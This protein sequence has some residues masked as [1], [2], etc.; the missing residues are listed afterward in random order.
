M[1]EASN[2]RRNSSRPV[3]GINFWGCCAFAIYDAAVAFAVATLLVPIELTKM[4]RGRSRRQ[5]LRERLGRRG[6]RPV[7]PH[8]HFL[9]H[10]VSVGEVHAAGALVSALIEEDARITVTLT[11]GNIEGRRA[12]G[13]LQQRIPEITSVSFL[14]WDHRVALRGWLRRIRPDATIIVETE[15]WPNLIRTAS[16]LSI[17]VLIVNGRVYPRDVPKYRLARGFFSSVL[18]LVEW[19]GVQSEQE[20]MAFE[21]IDAPA[22]RIHVV[23]NLKHDSAPS[24][25]LGT[26]WRTALERLQ[27]TPLIVAGSTHDPEEGWLIDAL[28]SVRKK[29]PAARMILA[30]RHPR[31]ARR[32]RRQAEAAG[33]SVV[34]WSDD[35]EAA[36]GWDALVIDRVGLLSALYRW[37]DIAVIGGSFADHGGHNPMEAAAFGRAILMGPFHDHFRDVVAGLD[38]GDGIHLLG[39]RE[40][41]PRL[42]SSALIDLVGD[43]V[44]RDSMG[45]RARVFAESQR[46]VG[47]A[48]AVSLLALLAAADSPRRAIDRRRPN[49]P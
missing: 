27:G 21:G 41:I 20:R 45:R 37:A 14:P 3:G 1:F 19:I 39:T 48:Y 17:P 23:G 13:L 6:D 8:P 9:I 18:A 22:D 33:L 47:R 28:L 12:A 43:P 46:G 32:V 40:D 42:M 31:R 36:G 26:P 25:V 5:W 10:A 7:E 29:T 4:A 49:L 38:Q 15:I 24:V 16:E 44:K 34:A 30:P 11:T 35:H 2:M